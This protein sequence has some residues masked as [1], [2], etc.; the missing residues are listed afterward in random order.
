MQGEAL[1]WSARTTKPELAERANVTQDDPQS[2]ARQVSTWIERL[3]YFLV[4]TGAVLHY[5]EHLAGAGV[6]LKMGLVYMIVAALFKVLD[7]IEAPSD[8]PT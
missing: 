1:H 7:D 4:I 6:F 5:Y 8:S 3:S 2:A